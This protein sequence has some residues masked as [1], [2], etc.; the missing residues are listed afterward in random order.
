MRPGV[1]QFYG[2]LTLVPPLEPEGIERLAEQQ[3]SPNDGAS[4]GERQV[5]MDL[6]HVDRGE[7]QQQ[8]RKWQTQAHAW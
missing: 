1:G 5:A 3:A 8:R 4:D 7:R 2:A 6:R